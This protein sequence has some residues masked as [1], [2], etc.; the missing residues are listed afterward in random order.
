MPNPDVAVPG[1]S[2]AA[3]RRLPRE[4]ERLDSLDL[5]ARVLTRTEG[6]IAEPRRIDEALSNVRDSPI[7]VTS[8]ASTLHGWQAQALFEAIVASLGSVRL[9]KLE[10]SGDIFF[11]GDSLKP[12][13]FRIVTLDGEQILVE[14]KN[15]HQK[16]PGKPYR[17]RRKDLDELQCY[18]HLVGIN[19]LKFGIYWSRWNDGTSGH[20]RI[21]TGSRRTVLTTWF[22][23][24]RMR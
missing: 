17:M 6:P 19:S 3:F 12:P 7:D 14:V 13:D 1:G 8:T 24:F 15:F 2:S 9:L 23:H 20:S 11:E 16:Q 18:T 22:Y 4:H 10:D 21:L 5:Y